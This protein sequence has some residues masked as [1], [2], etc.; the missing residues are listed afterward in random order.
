MW[1][2]QRRG[3]SRGRR[4][5]PCLYTRNLGRQCVDDNG[6]CLSRFCLQDFASHIRQ[7]V[8][9]PVLILG[10]E[11]GKNQLGEQIETANVVIRESPI[12]SGKRLQHAQVLA[13][14]AQRNQHGRAS[15]YLAREV[16]FDASVGFTIV[17]TK[18][19]ARCQAVLQK[20][21]VADEAKATLDGERAG[22]RAAYHLRSFRL[23]SFRLQAFR[24]R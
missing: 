12:S 17:A 7:P 4:G 11:R 1:S 14:A 6:L 21:G 16:E 19:A 3:N 15:S 23:R 18:N 24:Q 5:K 8:D 2:L 22:G 9:A 13:P 20:L 10:F